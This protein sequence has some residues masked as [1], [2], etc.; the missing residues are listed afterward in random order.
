MADENVT[1]NRHKYIGGSDIPIILGI[2]SFKTRWELL[3]EKAQI[4]EKEFDGNIYTEYG[5]IMEPIIREYTEK[6]YDTTFKVE[7]FID[8]NYRSNVDGINETTVLEIKTSSNPLDHIEVYKSQLIFYMMQ[9]GRQEGLLALYE[10]DYIPPLEN[11]TEEYFQSIFDPFKLTFIPIYLFEEQEL[12][13]KIKYEISRF[14][15]DL[16]TIKTYNDLGFEINEELLIAND[17]VIISR[18]LEIVENRI[19]ELKKAEDEQK[20]LKKKLYQAMCEYNIKSWETP[21]GVKITLIPEKNGEKVVKDQFDIET[22]QQDYPD[23]Y[24]EYAKDI[25]KK[26][27]RAGYVKITH[28]K[29]KGE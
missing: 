5:N 7:T 1:L 16:E 29:E 4:K 25:I 15:K 21:S 11:F 23:L 28:T 6:Q 17:V 14:L 27:K 19:K 3:L 8:E 12:L 13:E 26:D 10:R 24:D 18:E 9:S 22:F 20:L 2:S